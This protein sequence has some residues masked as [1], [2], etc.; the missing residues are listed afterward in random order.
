M[1]PAYK[2]GVALTPGAQFAPTHK[3]VQSLSPATGLPRHAAHPAT[4]AISFRHPC[5]AVSCLHCRETCSDSATTADHS[6][7]SCAL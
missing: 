3:V 1:V 2:S 6:G 4:S 5:F 7:S